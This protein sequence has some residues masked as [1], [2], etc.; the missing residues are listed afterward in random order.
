MTDR[1]RKLVPDS[2]NLVREKA[3]TTGICSEGWSPERSGI[4]RK[5]ELPGR[6]A[7]VKKF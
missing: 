7:K 2:Q 1:N 4:C 5:A 6:N 3:L